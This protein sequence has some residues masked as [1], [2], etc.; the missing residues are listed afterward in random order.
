ME[1]PL[2]PHSQTKDAIRA[3]VA[4]ELLAAD[5]YF[6]NLCRVGGWRLVAVFKH[7]RYCRE[8]L[9][10]AFALQGHTGRWVFDLWLYVVNALPWFLPAAFFLLPTLFWTLVTFISGLLS[11]VTMEP[12]LV[13]ASVTIPYLFFFETTKTVTKTVMVPVVNAP[14][15]RIAAGLAAATVVLSIAAL[16]Y[17][18]KAMFKVEMRFR[19]R[20][21]V[22]RIAAGE[23]KL[24]WRKKSHSRTV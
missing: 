17:V 9:D 10:K 18:L 23:R 6:D 20:L 19:R 15:I 11:Y 12:K 7:S 21:L 16:S 14:D 2:S 3:A 24:S 5:R 22:R 4:K 1:H 13:E 8:A